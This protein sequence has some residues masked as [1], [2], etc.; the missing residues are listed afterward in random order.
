MVRKRVGEQSTVAQRRT[1]WGGLKV[2]K[3]TSGKPQHLAPLPTHPPESAGLCAL[4]AGS[5]VDRSLTNQR[6]GFAARINQGAQSVV[7]VQLFWLIA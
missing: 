5:I 4:G 7:S 2:F 3:N 6:S 1:G